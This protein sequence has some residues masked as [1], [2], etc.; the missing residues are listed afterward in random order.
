MINISKDKI[1]KNKEAC[2][3]KLRVIFLQDLLTKLVSVWDLSCLN[4]WLIFVMLSWDHLKP[5]SLIEQFLPLKLSIGS[6][7]VLDANPKS[8]NFT[9]SF[10][11]SGKIF[12]GLITRCITTFSSHLMLVSKI[13]AKCRLTS[14]Q[15]M[16]F[17]RSYGP[18]WRQ[19]SL[20]K[21]LVV[22]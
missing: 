20:C 8:F 12:S 19:K 7:C 2:F 6:S 21:I 5:I 1:S 14:F 9:S 15:T 13:W 17:L 3:E 16:G 10:E 18:V 4:A 22:P 11:K